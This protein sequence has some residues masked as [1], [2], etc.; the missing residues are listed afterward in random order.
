MNQSI[1][2]R[3]KLNKHLHFQK[4]KGKFACI[5]IKYWTKVLS[6]RCSRHHYKRRSCPQ[7]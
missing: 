6:N 1:I 4:T 5:A 7:L 3:K 2:N